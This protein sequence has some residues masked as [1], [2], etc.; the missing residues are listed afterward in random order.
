M[1]N[2]N[3]VTPKW[4]IAKKSKQKQPE[5]KNCQYNRINIW[6]EKGLPDSFEEMHITFVCLVGLIECMLK[7]LRN[8]KKVGTYLSSVLL[9]AILVGMIRLQK[10]MIRRTI[11][12]VNYLNC[13]SRIFH[14][15][16]FALTTMCK[17]KG[18]MVL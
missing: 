11:K 13:H 9:S 7:K 17:T 5:Q 6:L 1:K 8:A 12:T 14:I 4:I 2:L 16:H 15:L 10:S 18:P 3:T